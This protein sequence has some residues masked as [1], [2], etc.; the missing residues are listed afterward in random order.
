MDSAAT[1]ESTSAEST[2][3]AAEQQDGARV[4]PMVLISQEQRNALLEYLAK[5]PYQDVAGG[6]DF[7]RNAPMVNVNLVGA[8]ADAA[9]A[10]AGQ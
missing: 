4:V 3:P 8:P 2:T 10:T 1:I 5:Q 7:L 9:T 6:I